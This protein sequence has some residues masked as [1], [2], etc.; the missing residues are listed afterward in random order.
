MAEYFEKREDAESYIK[1]ASRPVVLY[2]RISLH[3]S[4]KFMVDHDRRDIGSSP[5]AAIQVLEN[6][7]GEVRDILRR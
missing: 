7:T 4:Q 3:G 5:S 2:A 1:R 6:L